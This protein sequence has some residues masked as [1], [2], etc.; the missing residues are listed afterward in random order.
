MNNPTKFELWKRSQYIDEKVQEIEVIFDNLE[1]TKVSKSVLWDQLLP[2]MRVS[3]AV[4]YREALAYGS[5]IETWCFSEYPWQDNIQVIH[6]SHREAVKIHHYIADNMRNK[7]EGMISI[8]T[9]KQEGS[10]D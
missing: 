7:I 4:I 8:P 9:P 6:R 1:N 10:D 5:F 3:T 2:K